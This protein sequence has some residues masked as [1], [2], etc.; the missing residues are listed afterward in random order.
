MFKLKDVIK[1]NGATLNKNGVPK[2]MKRLSVSAKTSKS[3]QKQ[4]EKKTFDKTI[5]LS[6]AE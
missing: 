6:S 5:K 4:A 3:S 1:E 2:V